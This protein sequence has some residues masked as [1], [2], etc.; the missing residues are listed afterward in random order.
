VS[1]PVSQLASR[2]AAKP[3]PAAAKPP[4]P[5]QRSGGVARGGP[6]GHMQS[7][8]ATALQAEEEWKEF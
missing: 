1:K 7:T 6:V 3:R 4:T 8:L 5:V 2:P